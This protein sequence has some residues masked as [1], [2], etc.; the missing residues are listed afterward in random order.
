MTKNTKLSL[1]TRRQFIQSSA[2]AMGGTALGTFPGIISSA[3]A[4]DKLKG[5]F[6]FN[7]PFQADA[8][9]NVIDRF[10][11][12]QD[13]AEME[14]V[15]VPQNEIST[16]LATAIAGG[17]APSAARLG[18]PVLN[19][20]FIDRNQAVAIDDLEPGISDY[21]WIPAVKEAVSRDGKMYAVPVNSGCMCLLYNK[22]LYE[23]SGLD[24]E[25]PPTTLDELLEY[26][27]KIAKPDEQIWGHYVLTAPNL[28]TAR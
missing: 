28:Q 4:A 15:L 11:T 13:R 6:W 8:F 27:S 23:A 7:Q 18:G 16:K 25:K 19:S 17:D 22:D 26:A 1:L 3:T 20:L 12:G 5:T 2:L 14:F 10:K 9:N 21:D 24:P